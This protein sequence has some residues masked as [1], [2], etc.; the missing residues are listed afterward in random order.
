[1]YALVRWFDFISKAS[2]LLTNN[3]AFFPA[4]NVPRV[5]SILNIFAVLDVINC[6]AISL[7]T[8]WAATCPA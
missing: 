3:V 6:N 8:P 2:P 7:S 4:S 1:M 5:L